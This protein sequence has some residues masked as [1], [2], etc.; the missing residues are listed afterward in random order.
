[1]AKA[2]EEVAEME[3]EKKEVKKRP[4][5]RPKRTPTLQLEAADSTSAAAASNVDPD[6]RK[7]PRIDWFASAYIHDIIEAVRLHRSYRSAVE[8]LQRKFPKL[9]TE[10]EGRFERLN[11]STVRG[12][13]D[14]DFGKK[15]IS[16]SAW[17]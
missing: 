2:A 12:W 6:G 3:T 14:K 17:Y 7:K 15:C 4:V 16:P 5:G 1:M 9:P 13:Y 11:E 10:S 8:A